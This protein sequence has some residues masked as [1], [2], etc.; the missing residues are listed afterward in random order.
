MIEANADE[1]V[2]FRASKSSI[3]R[4]LYQDLNWFQHCSSGFNSGNRGGKYQT[5]S[6]SLRTHAIDVSSMYSTDRSP[7]TNSQRSLA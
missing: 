4:Y 5:W 3:N 2:S 6:V 7:L 1:S